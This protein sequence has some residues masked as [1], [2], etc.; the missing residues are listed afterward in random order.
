LKDLAAP[1]HV[2][3]APQFLVD[4]SGT[5]TACV[6]RQ[7][8][9]EGFWQS[10]GTGVRGHMGAYHRTL[11]TLLND[12]LAAGFHLEKLDE[13]VLQGGGLLAEVPRILLVTARAT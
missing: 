2:P 6:V 12:L 3:D 5:P 11:S 10:G 9:S 1:F 4:V 13:P 8:A 7:Y